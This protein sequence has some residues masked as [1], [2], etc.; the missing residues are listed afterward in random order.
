MTTTHRNRRPSILLSSRSS[1]VPDHMWSSCSQSALLD[2]SVRMHA[3][4][5]AASVAGVFGG[6][7]TVCRRRFRYRMT[8]KFNLFNVSSTRLVPEV[9]HHALLERISKG[10]LPEPTPHDPKRSVR[11]RY[12][13]ACDD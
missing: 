6:K 5:E 1:T 13:Y 11:P 7:E 3:R 4:I 2:R 10:R 12:S 9:P 8:S